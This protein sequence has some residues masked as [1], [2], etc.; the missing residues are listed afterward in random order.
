MALVYDCIRVVLDR[1][2]K[3]SVKQSHTLRLVCNNDQRVVAETLER[4]AKPWSASLGAFIETKWRIVN[5]EA[6]TSDG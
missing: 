4:A 6:Y 3:K 1:N 2:A 5:S